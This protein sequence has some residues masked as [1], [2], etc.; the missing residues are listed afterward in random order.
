MIE[1][2][3]KKIDLAQRTVMITTQDNQELT[4]TFP[5]GANIE[6]TEPTTMGT[7]GGDLEDLKEGYFV[8]VQL[9]A[10]D[11]D[12]KCSCASLICVS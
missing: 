4:L 6:V 1:G 11:S 9:G 12:G 8:E 2:Q 5:E 7:M 3:I 10:H